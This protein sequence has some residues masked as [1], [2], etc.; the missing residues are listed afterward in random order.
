MSIKPCEV[1]KQVLKLSYVIIQ[2]S[3]LSVCE[4]KL[5]LSALQLHKVVGEA[6]EITQVEF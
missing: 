6:G 1:A 5:L 2:W 3:S 4:G